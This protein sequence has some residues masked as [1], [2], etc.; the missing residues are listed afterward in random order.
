MLW[1]GIGEVKTLP[2]ESPLQHDFQ[3]SFIEHIYL[4]RQIAIAI[5]HDFSCNYWMLI[6]KIW[7]ADSVK[8][9]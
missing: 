7:W 2:F 1:V 9:G 4:C 8:G 6:L 3:K 5:I